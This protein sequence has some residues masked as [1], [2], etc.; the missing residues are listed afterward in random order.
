MNR[1]ELLERLYPR[2]PRVT[3]L[4]GGGG[5][6]TLLSALGEM[7][8]RRGERVLLTTTTHLGWTP[9]AVSPDSTEDLNRRLVPGRAVLAGY[10]DAEHH[11]L[12]GIPTAWYAQLRADRI[13]VEADGSR[14]LPLKYHRAFEPVVP[15]DAGLV[16]ELA[17]LAALGRPAGEVIH[18]WREAG[19]DPGRTV[20][21]ALCAVLL[22]RGLNAARSEAPKLVLLNQADTPA[23]QAQGEALARLLEERSVEAYVTQ[24]KESHIKLKC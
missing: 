7:C 12:T 14:C 8:A 4:I 23:L 6:T 3:A 2:L 16:I 13:L 20:D 24:L 15:P 1:T 19:I 21:E 11:K 18:G 9:R 17:G 22:E 10:P 5:K